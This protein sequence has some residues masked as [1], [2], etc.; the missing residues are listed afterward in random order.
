MGL[1]YKISWTAPILTLW[2]VASTLRLRRTT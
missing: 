2:L 1:V